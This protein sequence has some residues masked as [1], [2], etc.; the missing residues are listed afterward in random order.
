MDLGIDQTLVQNRH[1]L[2]FMRRAGVSAP[3]PDWIA[4]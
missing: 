1:V 4:L 3:N 2:Y